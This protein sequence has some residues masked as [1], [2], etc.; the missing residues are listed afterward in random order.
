MAVLNPRSFGEL[1]FSNLPYRNVVQLRY[2]GV[3]VLYP[4]VMK[5][6]TNPV[7]SNSSGTVVAAS[8]VVALAAAAL[9][10][11]VQT[12]ALAVLAVAALVATPRVRRTTNTLRRTRTR[13]SRQICVPAT[14]VCVDV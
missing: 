11:A 2:M 13:H 7:E 3:G 12:P 5:H 1:S 14:D 6:S 4:T 9:V 8:L 10:L